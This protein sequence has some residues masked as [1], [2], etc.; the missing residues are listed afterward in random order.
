MI[1]PQDTRTLP[2]QL[3]PRLKWPMKPSKKQQ[4]RCR[5]WRAVGGFFHSK[6]SD[7]VQILRSEE[8]AK[9]LSSLGAFQAGRDALPGSC[10]SS[11]GT[12]LGRKQQQQVPHWQFVISLGAEKH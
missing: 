12:S 7:W 6:V 1:P 3:P 5:G 10:S 4:C 2:S 9:P 8:K 11:V